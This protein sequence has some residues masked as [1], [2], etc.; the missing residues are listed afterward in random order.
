MIIIVLIMIIIVLAV[1][2][3]WNKAW[4]LMIFKRKENFSPSSS[5]FVHICQTVRFWA[6]FSEICAYS[7][8]HIV[9]LPKRC[10]TKWEFMAV[11]IWM[12][13]ESDILLMAA[14]MLS[15][16]S[17]WALQKVCFL[18]RAADIIQPDGTRVSFWGALRHTF[19]IPMQQI[20]IHFGQ[21]ACNTSALERK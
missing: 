10:L 4:L 5:V 6:P 1:Y 19:S 18:P 2:V 11:V 3:P 8:T 12:A 13:N 7:N 17:P 15:P 9:M 16:L 20:H 14:V 21:R